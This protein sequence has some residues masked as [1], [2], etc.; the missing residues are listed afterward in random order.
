MIF[1]WMKNK[2]PHCVYVKKRMNDDILIV[3]GKDLMI[4]YLNPTAAS[5]FNYTDGKSSISDIKQRFLSD[6]D[7]TES[8]L[9]Q[10][11]IKLIRDL[12]WK[13]LIVLE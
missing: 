11:L 9:E 4:Y 13:K 7:V 8:E 5:F 6:F 2:I 1:D 3:T 10:D 12:Q